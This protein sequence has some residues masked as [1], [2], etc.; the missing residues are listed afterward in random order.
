[1]SFLFLTAASQQGGWV[2]TCTWEMTH[3]GQL[4]QVGRRISQTRQHVKLGKREIIGMLRV[5]PFVS[6][7]HHHTWRNSALPD[8]SEHLPANGKWWMNSL[9]C[10][11]CLSCFCFVFWTVF[12]SVHKFSYFYSSNS[13]LHSTQGERMSSCALL[14]YH[15]GLTHNSQCD[16]IKLFG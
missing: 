1:M 6:P 4:T 15:L 7:H 13:L 9:I 12:I 14:S 8:M 3:L 10:F 11:G 5:I 16:T 2:C